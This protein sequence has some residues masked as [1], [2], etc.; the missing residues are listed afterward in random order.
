MPGKDYCLVLV[1]DQKAGQFVVERFCLREDNKW[2][3]QILLPPELQLQFGTSV[4]LHEDSLYAVGGLK[5]SWEKVSTARK[6]DLHT[7]TWLPLDDMKTKR[8]FCSCL[9]FNDTVYVGGGGT[10]GL[11]SC[12]TVEALRLGCQGWTTIT[13]TTNYESSLVAIGSRLV[14]TG[15]EKREN[16]SYSNSVELFE[17]RWGEWLSLP[18]MTHE[19]SWH[20]ILL[21]QNYELVAAGG[22]DLNSIESLRFP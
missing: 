9:V 13:Q 11:N 18:C 14:A 5:R 10:K 16:W 2:H 4:V 8:S 20:G 22:V 6:C 3:S 17:D 21:S 1:Q 12:C 7:G 19:R 15:G